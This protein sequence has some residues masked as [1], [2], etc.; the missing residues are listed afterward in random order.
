MLLVDAECSI[1]PERHD[2]FVR[3]VRKIV[4]LVRTEAGCLRYDLFSDASVPGIF[5]FIEEWESKKHLDDHIAQPHMQEYFAT[6]GAWQVSPTR[7][8]MYEIL[9]LRSMVMDS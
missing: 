7:L 8:K 1:V 3:E 9:S 2:D 4:P 6:T 5:H